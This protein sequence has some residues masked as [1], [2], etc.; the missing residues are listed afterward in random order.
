MHDSITLDLEPLLQLPTQSGRPSGHCFFRIHC[1]Q[2]TKLRFDVALTWY[3][4]PRRLLR[5]RNPR[6][7][8]LG[9]A[10]GP[11]ELTI[12]CVSMATCRKYLIEVLVAISGSILILTCYANKVPYTNTR[13]TNVVELEMDNPAWPWNAVTRSSQVIVFPFLHRILAYC[14]SDLGGWLEFVGDLS[15]WVKIL[16]SSNHLSEERLSLAALAPTNFLCCGRLGLLKDSS[17]GT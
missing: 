6:M 16:R 14:Y 10:V 3:E 2:Y 12:I 1:A 15:S 9:F 17:S 4:S 5:H 7:R 11:I 13:R 8:S